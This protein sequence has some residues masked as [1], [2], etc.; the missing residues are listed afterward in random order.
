MVFVA[1]TNNNMSN[2]L[3]AVSLESRS[4]KSDNYPG[5]Y[6]QYMNCS[7]L[8]MAAKGLIV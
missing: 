4:L 6:P 3:T 7:W 1:C 8:I 2:N 5:S